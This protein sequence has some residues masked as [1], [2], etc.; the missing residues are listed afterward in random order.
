VLA[1]CSL[2]LSASPARALQP[3]TPV[4]TDAGQVVA[5]EA[6][7]DFFIALPS[8]PTTGYTWTQLLGDGKILAYEGNVYQPPSAGLMGAGGEQ[9]FIY[10][11]NRSG[12]TTIS[13]A[14]ARPFEPNAPPAKSL[15]FSVTVQ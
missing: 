1:A 5:V 15:T 11:A 4:F 7:D 6:G 9:L 3:H 13:F 12:S 14:Y 10:H 2:V 8:N